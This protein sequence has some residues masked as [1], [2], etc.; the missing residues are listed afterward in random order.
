MNSKLSLVVR[1]SAMSTFTARCDRGVFIQKSESE[2]ESESKSCCVTFSKAMLCDM[3]YWRTRVRIPPGTVVFL[4]LQ[5]DLQG[6]VHLP[7]KFFMH[8][9]YCT[10]LNISTILVENNQIAISLLKN[11]I[12]I[13]ILIL[14]IFWACSEDFEKCFKNFLCFSRRKKEFSQSSG[15]NLRILPVIWWNTQRIRTAN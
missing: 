6:P 12:V 13:M 10:P 15:G 3:R 8:F 11:I 14:V 5:M 1:Q 2:S 4:P 9:L 7:H